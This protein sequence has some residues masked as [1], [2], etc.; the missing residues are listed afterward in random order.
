MY[1][2]ADLP[3]RWR[4]APAKKRIWST[5]GGISSAR[6]TATGLPVFC[7]STRTRSSAR[8]SM[9]SAMRKRARL[10]SDGVASRHPGKA[11]AAA[12]H[13]R[14][15]VRWPRTPGPRGTPRPVLGSTSM[16]VAPSL[17]ST[18]R[19]PTKLESRPAVAPV[20]GFWLLT[21]P[22]RMRRRWSRAAPTHSGRLPDALQ[23]HSG[24]RTDRQT[25]F[26]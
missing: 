2:P 13:G 5:I 23:G 26:F 12:G 15:D 22:P 11:S 24:R 17:V 6:V 3:S 10:R 4:A 8:A 14:V 19:P 9:A 21:R 7:V 18:Y 16:A 1:S 25:S 20:A